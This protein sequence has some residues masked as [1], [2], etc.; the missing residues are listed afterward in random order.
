MYPSL[1]EKL[2][3]VNHRLLAAMACYLALALISVFTLTGFFRT[4]VLFYFA[5]LA[6]KTIAH[7]NDEKMD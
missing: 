3:T 7:S 6:I 5:I 4:V 1:H 2:K